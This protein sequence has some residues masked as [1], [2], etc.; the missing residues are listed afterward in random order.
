MGRAQRGK[1]LN[2]PSDSAEKREKKGPG[3]HFLARMQNHKQDR[4]QF[5][6]GVLGTW[7]VSWWYPKTALVCLHPVPS[8]PPAT[9]TEAPCIGVPMVSASSLFYRAR[10]RGLLIALLNVGTCIATQCEPWCARHDKPWT[11]KC[12]WAGCN[13]CSVC[14]LNTCEAWCDAHPKAWVEKCT[15]QSCDGC[16]PCGST[17]Q[18]CPEFC[19]ATDPCT[20]VGMLWDASSAK[21]TV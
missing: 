14:G 16:G 6:E 3:A 12:T 5:W 1:K 17:P 20:D 11:A 7:Y 10:M 21:C 15:F 18:F 2:L 13:G 8:P 19:S 4:G 9:C